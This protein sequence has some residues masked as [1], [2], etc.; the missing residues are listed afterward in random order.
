[1]NQAQ[2]QHTSSVKTR[3]LLQLCCRSGCTVCVLDY[4]E[5][6][7]IEAVNPEMLALLEALEQAEKLLEPQP[8][9]MPL[10]E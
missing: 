7:L 8:V 10:T 4:P 6:M 2:N 5:L 3:R 1:M 9:R